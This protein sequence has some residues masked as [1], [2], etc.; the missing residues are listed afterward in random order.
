MV[1]T[2]NLYDANGT[3]GDPRAVSFLATYPKPVEV[4]FALAGVP[5]VGG[6]K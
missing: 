4:P 5:V 1:Y 2:F 3:K 6:K